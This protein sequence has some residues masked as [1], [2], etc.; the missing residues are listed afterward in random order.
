MRKEIGKKHIFGNT[1]LVTRT[2]Q[3]NGAVAVCLS[4]TAEYNIKIYKQKRSKTQT[5]DKIEL[6][7]SYKIKSSFS[8]LK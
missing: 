1:P 5:I 7:K 2:F 3:T 8:K 4:D 6:K